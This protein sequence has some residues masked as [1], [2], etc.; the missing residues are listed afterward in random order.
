MAERVAL[1]NPDQ[2]RHLLSGFTRVDDL[3]RDIEALCRGE[4]SPFARERLDLTAEEAGF[5]RAFTGAARR[6]MLAACDRLGIARP[7]PRVSARWAA[8]TCLHY[9]DISFA[10]LSASGMRGYGA[11]TP[12]AAEELAD[13]AQALSALMWRGIALLH[14]SDGGSLA[15][16][17]ARIPGPAG[18]ILGQ[19]ERITAD[20]GL[21]DLRPLLAAAIDR[22]ASDGLDVGVFGR[23]SSGKS[24]MLNS[25]IGA[26]V[27]PVGT[28]PVTAVSILVARGEPGLTAHLADGS[29]RQGSLA[30]VPTFATERENPDNARGVRTL[31]VRVA[32][33]PKDLRL[34]DTPGVGSLSTSGPAQAFATLPRCDL[35]LVLVAAGTAM[36]PEDLALVRGLSAAGIPL[37]VL[38][39]KADLLTVA[40]REAALQH[41]HQEV[42]R[43]LGQGCD[44]TVRPISVRPDFQG[45]RDALLGEDLI[46]ALQER[47]RHGHRALAGRLRRLVALAASVLGPKGDGLDA[48]LRTQRVLREASDQVRSAC[49]D[50]ARDGTRVL[51]LTARAVGDAWKRGEN[52]AEAAE[53]ALATSAAEHARRVRSSVDA[54]RGALGVEASPRLPPLF[55][56]DFLKSLPELTP[57]ASRRGSSVEVAASRRLATLAPAVEQAFARYAA[58]LHAWAEGALN[59]IAAGAVEAPEARN[60]PPELERLDAMARELGGEPDAAS[61]PGPLGASSLEV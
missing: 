21:S 42:R 18:E 51:G 49:D 9:A 22:A 14:E 28:T 58:R 56:P 46:P 12:Y 61:R 59:E 35:G 24:S 43:A 10:E 1:L 16:R 26:P 27:L 31:E 13:V 38:L 55:D 57:P 25:I 60:L 8:E 17:A 41:L 20:R 3:L 32:G 7:E 40:E 48:E 45:W 50:L 54:L 5:L 4:L 47:R 15:G 52:G 53:E 30:E 6:R 19:L 44:A 2:T 33:L 29:I 37:R 34:V 23:V 36:G 11:L 39:S